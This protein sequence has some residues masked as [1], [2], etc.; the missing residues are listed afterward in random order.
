[1]GSSLSIEKHTSNIDD[2]LKINNKIY[3]QIEM[4]DS[5]PETIGFHLRVHFLPEFQ[6]FIIPK[7]NPLNP[8]LDVEVY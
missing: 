7:I 5:V 3:H 1:M 8:T 6:I 4:N 2:I